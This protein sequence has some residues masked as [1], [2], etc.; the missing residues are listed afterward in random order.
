VPPPDTQMLGRDRRG[1]ERWMSQQQV[2]TAD[3]SGQVVH[4]AVQRRKDETPEQTREA[5]KSPLTGR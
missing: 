5:D 3:R 1:D 4:V 2:D